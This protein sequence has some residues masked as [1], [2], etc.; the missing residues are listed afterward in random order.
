MSRTLV[1]NM[2]GQLSGASPDTLRNSVR[3]TVVRLPVRL[4]ARPFD[5]SPIFVA[6][7]ASGHVSGSVSGGRPD[8]H[9]LSLES[10][11]SAC[12]TLSEPKA[13]KPLC[14]SRLV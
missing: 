3:R 1:Q 5:L 7:I 6:S 4:I 8:R 11:L 9:S 2:P 10:V 14:A 13:L 12:P